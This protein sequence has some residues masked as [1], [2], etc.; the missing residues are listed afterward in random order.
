[1]RELCGRFRGDLAGSESYGE[2]VF[3]KTAM[4]TAFLGGGTPEF[5]VHDNSIER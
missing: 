4:L 1:M 5:R 2:M 3:Y